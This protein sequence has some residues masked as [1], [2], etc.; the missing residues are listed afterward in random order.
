MR[1]EFEFD[2][3]QK[4]KIKL[5]GLDIIGRIIRAAVTGGGIIYDV[6]YFWEGEIKMRD[7]YAEDLEAV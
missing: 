5:F 4:V 1:A 3:K 2:I 6:E 7:F